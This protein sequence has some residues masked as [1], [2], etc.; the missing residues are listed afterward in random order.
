MTTYL[1]YI[2]RT[3]DVSAYYGQR[4]AGDTLVVGSLI[5]PD[6]GGT[7]CTGALMVAQ[8]WLLRFARETDSSPYDRGGSGFMTA[9]RRGQLRTELDVYQE[10][11]L[12]AAGVRGEMLAAESGDEPDDER[13]ASATLNGVTVAPDGVTMRVTILTQAGTSRAVI[14][15]LPIVV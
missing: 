10:F 11:N 15:P 1:D 4:E 7:V 2:D 6:D 8:A 3:V 5:G 14:L 9:L 12:A 13:F